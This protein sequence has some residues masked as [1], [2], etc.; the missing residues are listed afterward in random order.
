[1]ETRAFKELN[2]NFNPFAPAASGVFLAEELWIPGSWERNLQKLLDLLLK[3]KGIKA[4]ALTGEYGSGKSF[5]LNWCREKYFREKHILPFL[6][7]NP[8]LQFYDLANK[9]LRQ[10]GRYEFSKSLWELLIHD[11]TLLEPSLFKWKFSDWLSTIADKKNKEKAIKEFRQIIMKKD[12]ARDEEIAYRLAI[13]VVE[14]VEKPYFEYRDFV[15]GRKGSLVA[16]KEEAPYFRSI[17]KVLQRATGNKGIALLIDEFE[18]VALQKRLNRRQAHEYL[19]TLRRLLNVSEEEN[20][21]IV[22]SMTP[23]AA[24]VTSELD[25]ALWQRFTNQGKYQFEIP[26]LE[27]IEAEEIIKKRLEKA[28]IDIEKSELFPFP[29]GLGR[30]LDASIISTPRRLIKVC[31]FILSE[32]ASRKNIKIPLEKDFIKNVE[33]QLYGSRRRKS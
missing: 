13:L 22:V 16:E 17:I 31:F 3:G 18:E 8:G 5:L 28:K 7:D 20:F 14:T 19:A 32:A 30:I 29:D 1:M 9:L 24:K 2:L 10:I 15:A 21:W 6:F 4:L 25:P 33:T 26:P 23:Q 11:S 12:I 27:R